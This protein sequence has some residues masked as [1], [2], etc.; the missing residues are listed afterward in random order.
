LNVDSCGSGSLHLEKPKMWSPSAEMWQDGVGL[1][2]SVRYTSTDRTDEPWRRDQARLFTSRTSTDS[3]KATRLLPPCGGGGLTYIQPNEGHQRS[4]R[5][6]PRCST[7]TRAGAYVE[8]EIH[9]EAGCAVQKW[10]R[11]M[12]RGARRKARGVRDKAEGLRFMGTT[13]RGKSGGQFGA[14][15]WK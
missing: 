9:V 8:E 12:D 4:K 7:E 10:M 13:M 1:S 11:V 5:A 3:H 14:K 6:I 2:P 15:E